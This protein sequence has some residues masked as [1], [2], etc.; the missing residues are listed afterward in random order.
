MHTR[1]FSKGKNGVPT[2]RSL[3]MTMVVSSSLSSMPISQIKGMQVQ[4]PAE[5][6][7][8][9]ERSEWK[10]SANLQMSSLYSASVICGRD[11]KQAGKARLV[12]FF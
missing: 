10:R 12:L 8:V 4:I 3:L 6:G 5:A 7:Q 11:L 9:T 2:G 1:V